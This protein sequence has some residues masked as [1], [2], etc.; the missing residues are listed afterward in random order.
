[1]ANGGVVP[2]QITGCVTIDKGKDVDGFLDTAWKFLQKPSRH[3][4]RVKAAANLLDGLKAAPSSHTVNVIGHG[5]QGT[6]YTG[7]GDTPTSVSLKFVGVDNST[8]W[9]AQKNLSAIGKSAI[10]LARLCA[11]DTGAGPDGAN[12]LFLV[13]KT[14]SVPVEAPTGLLFCDS[15]DGFF[16]EPYATWQRATPQSKPNPIDPPQQYVTSPAMDSLLFKSSTGYFTIP[17][18]DVTAVSITPAGP[19][20]FSP[21]NLAGSHA[22]TATTFVQFNKPFESHA[23]PAAVTSGTFLVS[24]TRNGR[25]EQRALRIYNNRLLRDLT[26]SDVYYYANILDLIAATS[27]RKR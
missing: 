1:M 26:M 5:Y 24:F 22:Q 7:S 23:V 11:C 2:V 27:V 6:I 14:V 20:R 21:V 8:D 16:L 12:L 10:S 18:A 9:A 15:V 25:D 17:L 4:D 13:A 3:I 19:H